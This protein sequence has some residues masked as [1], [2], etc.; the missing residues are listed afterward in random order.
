M[1]VDRIEN[2]DVYKKLSPDIYVGLEYIRDV[3]SNIE[4]GT[5][6]INDNVKAIVSEYETVEHFE[7]GFE[8]HKHVID[9][10]YPIIGLE[11]V[12]WSPIIGMDVNIPYEV[13]K[14]RT[15]YKNPHQLSTHVDI[16]NGFFAI[17]FP[18]DGH[19]PQ[20]FVNNSE[21]IKKITIKVSI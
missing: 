14:D 8:A 9:I 2:I 16:G 3:K 13:E 11:R 19:G 21:F 10:Q 15:F 17:M 7:R 1:I 20:H 6:Q 18:G 5:Y 12:K 4:L